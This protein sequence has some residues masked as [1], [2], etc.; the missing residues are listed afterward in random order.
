[1]VSDSD[2]KALQTQVAQLTNLL[3]QKVLGNDPSTNLGLSSQAVNFGGPPQAGSLTLQLNGVETS[4]NNSTDPDLGQTVSMESLDLTIANGDKLAIAPNALFIMVWDVTIPGYKVIGFLADD[5]VGS[6]NL[7]LSM[8][9]NNRQIM[10]NNA[11]S[12]ISVSD[13]VD[14]SFIASGGITIKNLAGVSGA[15]TAGGHTLTFTNG[16]LT[17]FV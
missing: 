12:D 14:T 3:R 10:L 16:I 15:V 17:A 5:G 1:M 7:T 9:G 13:G 11:G 2:F 8:I 4:I 6:G